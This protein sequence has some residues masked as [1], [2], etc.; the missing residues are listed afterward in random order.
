VT[1]PRAWDDPDFADWA[2]REC[3]LE[4]RAAA[5]LRAW[6]VKAGEVL[7]GVPDDQGIVVR[8]VS[9]TRWA[10]ATP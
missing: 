1:P 6:L 9:P 8:V 2:Q 5:A 7:D 10:A 4:P 3:G